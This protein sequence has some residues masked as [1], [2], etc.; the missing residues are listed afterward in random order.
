M[1]LTIETTVHNLFAEEL[2]LSH[3]TLPNAEQLLEMLI[4][5]DNGWSFHL[6]HDVLF[7]NNDYKSGRMKRGEISLCEMIW[8]Y[9]DPVHEEIKAYQPAELVYVCLL[10]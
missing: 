9:D 3:V 2:R 4:L 8:I 6:Y 10:C 5:P 1:I 7:D